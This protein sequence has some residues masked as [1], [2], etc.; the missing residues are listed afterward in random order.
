MNKLKIVKV[1]LVYIKYL[2]LYHYI[3]VPLRLQTKVYNIYIYIY[4]YI[5]ICVCDNNYAL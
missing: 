1:Y 4:I 2:A 3:I 5:Y